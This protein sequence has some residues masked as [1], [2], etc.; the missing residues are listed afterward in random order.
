MSK[1]H[2]SGFDPAP[3]SAVFG[4]GTP[5]SAALFGLQRPSKAVGG[6]RLAGHDFMS[7]GESRNTSRASSEATGRHWRTPL[8]SAGPGSWVI[9]APTCE[10]ET[11]KAPP[12]FS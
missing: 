10:P 2:L 4:S 3:P 12:A 6:G 7:F 8:A 9:G 11:R 5:A 1:P